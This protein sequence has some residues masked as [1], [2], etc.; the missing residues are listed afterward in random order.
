MLSAVH[1]IV[2][3]VMS[4]LGHDTNGKLLHSSDAMFRAR[5]QSF[6]A[7]ESPEY[8][9]NGPFAINLWAKTANNSG[10]GPQFLL[11]HQGDSPRTIPGARIRQFVFLSRASSR[12]SP[13]V[14][15]DRLVCRH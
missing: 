1:D 10:T 15:V 8:A 12:P 5:L 3:P 14:Q 4:T 7:L 9:T 13:Q 6:L 2:G 11:S